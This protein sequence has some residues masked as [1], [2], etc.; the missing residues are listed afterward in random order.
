MEQIEAMQDNQNT[1]QENQNNMQNQ[2]NKLTKMLEDFAKGKLEV[3]AE[4]K[5]QHFETTQQHLD[6]FSTKIEQ[7]MKHFETKLQQQ[8]TIQHQQNNEIEGIKSFTEGAIGKPHKATD[9]SLESRFDKIEQNLGTMMH[10]MSD[11]FIKR[12][13]E[14]TND[15]DGN[16]RKKPND[17]TL[18]S[19]T[20]NP[21]SNY[22]QETL[23]DSNA[24]LDTDYQ[25]H[26]YQQLIPT[27]VVNTDYHNHESQELLPTQD[28]PDVE[29][30]GD[31]DISQI[32]L[33]H[34]NNMSFM[35]TASDN[36]DTSQTDSQQ[37]N[38]NNEDHQQSPCQRTQ[39]HRF[40]D[41]TTM[42]SSTTTLQ[43]MNL[44]ETQNRRKQEA[45][46]SPV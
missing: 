8:E 11:F 23:T 43:L 10:N 2:L 4:T 34:D 25:N 30:G 5:Q 6:K 16:K 40:K 26:E 27:T 33:N 37:E 17:E 3:S 18:T 7:R 44:K 36:T 38:I 29:F 12:F 46:G 13:S 32:E 9:A 39:Q 24:V 45:Q 1:M 31:Q 28:Q 14:Q 41:P 15:T 35:S 19:S 21:T 20:A 22:T 42:K